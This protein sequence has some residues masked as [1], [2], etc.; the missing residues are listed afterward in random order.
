M[1]RSRRWKIKNRLVA[2]SGIALMVCL[3]GGRAEA[4]A[5]SPNPWVPCGHLEDLRNAAH[6]CEISGFP[7][8]DYEYGF[9]FTSPEIYVANCLFWNFGMRVSNRVPHLVSS[10]NPSLTFS[11]GGSV[12]YTD[13][14]T[15]DDDI[16]NACPSGT[17]RH[18]YWRI[19]TNGDVATDIFT[20]GC[21]NHPLFC[22][23]RT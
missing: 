22:R 8:T 12:F 20:V 13:T 17:W 14:L 3:A 10:D 6:R 1:T 21:V 16:P 7:L 23:K 2:L 4:Q 11:L 19:T 5:V 9:A 18:R 15:T